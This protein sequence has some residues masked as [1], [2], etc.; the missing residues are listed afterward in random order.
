M[1]ASYV[2][3]GFVLLFVLVSLIEE[4]RH[5][6]GISARRAFSGSAGSG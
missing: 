2:I 5:Q 6:P 3:L 4:L 1:I